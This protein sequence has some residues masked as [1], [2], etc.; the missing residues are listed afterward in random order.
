MNADV[1]W[2]NRLVGTLS[3]I[4]ADQPQNRGRIGDV[5]DTFKSLSYV[6]YPTLGASEPRPLFP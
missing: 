3:E 5:A 2:E 1:F 4:E 6:P